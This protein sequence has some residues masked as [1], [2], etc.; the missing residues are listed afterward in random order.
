MS[1]RDKRIERL[2]QNPQSVRFEEIETIL[3]GLGFKRRQKGSH[4]VFSMGKFRTTVPIKKPFV[5]RTY[6]E[7]VLKLLDEL[8]NELED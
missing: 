5:K 7:D 3:E 8:L 1:K 4:V 6:V 2:R